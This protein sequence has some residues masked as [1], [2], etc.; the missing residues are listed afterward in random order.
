MDVAVWLR[1]LGLQQ[2]E[3]LFRENDIDAEAVGDLTDADLEKLRRDFAGTASACSRRSFSLGA[4]EPAPKADEPC[5]PNPVNR[6]CRAPPDHGRC[7]AI[8][9][10][11]QALL[12]N[13]TPRTGATSSTLISTKRRLRSLGLAV[14]C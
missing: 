9:S 8:L 4:T 3:A 11:R 2:Y 10:A 13:L 7:S 1:N 14:M 6:R 5:A 12:R